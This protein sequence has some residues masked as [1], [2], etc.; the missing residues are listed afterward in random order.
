LQDLAKW[1]ITPESIEDPGKK[2]GKKKPDPGTLRGLVYSLRNAIAHFNVTPVPRTADVHSFVFTT[3]KGF[4]ATIKI[5]EMR[6]F[7]GSLAQYLDNH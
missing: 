3:E 6:V 7:V 4:K 5:E 1:G 2:A